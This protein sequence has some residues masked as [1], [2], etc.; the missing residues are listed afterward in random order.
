MPE[1]EGEKIIHISLP[2]GEGTLLMGNDVPATHGKAIIGTNFYITISTKSKEEADR[3]FNG[4]AAGG[5]VIMPLEKA[6]WGDYFGVLKDKFD[7]QWM[8]TYDDNQQQ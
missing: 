6:F 3:L 2:I 7:I 8:M 4:L 1:I 5:Q